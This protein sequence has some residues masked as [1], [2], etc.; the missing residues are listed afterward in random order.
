MTEKSKVRLIF[1]IS[2][3]ASSLLLF[4]FALFL[5]L[6]IFFERIWKECHPD[7][8]TCSTFIYGIVLV[9]GVSCLL[10]LYIASRTI[11]HFIHTIHTKGSIRGMLRGA[12]IGFLPVLSLLF[13]PFALV[14]ILTLPFSL[15]I[16]LSFPVI[17]GLAAA[18]GFS[19]N[20]SER[21]KTVV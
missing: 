15:I 14:L 17:F 1:I 5:D 21:K 16:L 11:P 19:S 8:F 12:F 4:W 13:K 2:A 18:I 6:F 7:D 9:Y 3:M 20:V 10:T